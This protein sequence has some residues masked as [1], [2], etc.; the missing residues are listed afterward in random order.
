M[1]QIHVNQ[2]LAVAGFVKHLVKKCTWSKRSLTLCCRSYSHL[3][4]SVTA[5]LAGKYGTHCLS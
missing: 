4:L 3:R 5:F 1:N 2:H